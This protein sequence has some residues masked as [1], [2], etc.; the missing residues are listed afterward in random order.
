MSLHFPPT[1]VR[2]WTV[3]PQRGGRCPIQCTELALTHPHMQSRRRGVLHVVKMVTIPYWEESTQLLSV[4]VFDSN[5]N[6]FFLQ[7]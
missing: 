2:L 7:T 5:E 4:P 6:T 3:T 1:G